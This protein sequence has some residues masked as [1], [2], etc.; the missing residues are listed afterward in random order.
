M[1]LACCTYQSNLN[2]YA[3]AS[4][5]DPTRTLTLR[6]SF[7]MDMR[8]RFNKVN[9][10]IYEAIVTQ[11]VFA[12]Q[13]PTTYAPGRRAFNFP[14][15]QGKVASFMDWL[16]QLQEQEILTV[17]RMPQLGAAT[18]VAWTD[19]YVQD[20]YKRGV[21][22]ARHEMGAA[23][24]MVPSIETTGGITASMSTP[25]HMDR[26]GVLYSRVFSELQNI[27]S[28]MDNQISKVLAQGLIDGD[29]PRLLAKKIHGTM[30]G[31]MPGLTDSLGRFM[32]GA[33][34]AEILART[35][36]IRAHHVG[37]IQEYK[38]WDVVGVKVLAEWRT[39]GDTRVCDE[40]A[41]LQARGVPYSLDE[42][43][44][45][46]PK[47][48]QCRCIVLP[49]MPEKQTVVQ[50]PISMFDTEPT[51][52]EEQ[53]AWLKDSKSGWDIP[54]SIS[55][56]NAIVF[57]KKHVGDGFNFRQMSRE[58]DE[59]TTYNKL[60][61]G[62][63]EIQFGKDFIRVHIQ[64][65]YGDFVLKRLFQKQIAHHILLLIP[66]LLQGGGM[67]KSITKSLYKQY[68]AAKIK[69]IEL[70][71]GL[72][73]GGY[74]WARYGFYHEESYVVY[75]LVTHAS[76][77][78]PWRAEALKIVDDFM[79]KYPK[80]PFPMHLL[81]DAPFGKELLLNQNWSG[82]LDLKNTKAVRRFEDYLTYI[83][84]R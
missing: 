70:S 81:A 10:Q 83:R 27:T 55:D 25:F 16:K 84:K 71:A 28:A 75:N 60:K 29:G 78:K 14:T 37:M 3:K 13:N 57:L 36:V 32:P 52:M 64:N 18:N 51:T 68:K 15:T 80:K 69:R 12:L 47:H 39:A 76:F 67:S 44:G 82:F 1:G 45:L 42:A 17:T 74:T 24:M 35:E 22:R 73:V 56:A 38:N 4:R 40:C 62:S 7:V 58:L 21:I 26:V 19:M 66:K 5:V 46:I 49:T 33:R 65:D 11:D 31:G 77:Q 41:R 30:H 48:P 34:R 61:I 72:D 59:I 63:R 9:R 50:E 54:S 53:W 23:G 20:S 2:T 6:N 79:S 8:R 43:E